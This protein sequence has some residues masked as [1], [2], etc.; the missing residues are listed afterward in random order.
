MRKQSNLPKTVSILFLML[1]SFFISLTATGQDI[2]R[3]EHPQPQF[4]RTKWINLNGTWDFTMQSNIE[5]ASE[6]WM[7]KPA[8]FDRKII[9][10]F[11]PESPLSGIGYTDYIHV[12]WYKRTFRIPDDWKGQRI[13]VNFG[14]VDFDSRVWVNDQFIGRHVGGTGSFEYEIT[15]AI[16]NGDNEIVIHS[17]DNVMDDRQPLGKQARQEKPRWGSI[18][19]T[20]VTGIWQTVWLEARPEKFIERVNIVPDLDKNEFS[21]T[22]EFNG[23]GQGDIFEIVVSSADGKKVASASAPATDGYPLTVKIL[24]PR[25]WTTTDPYLYNFDLVLKTA[26]GETDNVKSYAGMRKFH[27]EGNRFFLNNKPIFLRMVLDQG[28]YP[29]GQWT[30]PTDQALKNDIQLSIDAG[31]NSARLHQKVF[32]PR[33]HYWADKLGYLTW[34]EFSDWGGVH[35]FK[36]VEGLYI[37]SNEWREAIMRDR[38]HPSIIAWTPFNETSGA[39]SNDIEFY[40]YVVKNFYDLTHALDP[41]RPVNT[42]SGYVNVYT[43]IFTVHDYTQDH[44]TFR[45]RYLTVDPKNPEKAWVSNPKLSIPYAGQPY[46][47]DEYG[48][49]GWLPSYTDSKPPDGTTNLMGRFAIG[50]GKTADEVLVIV[51]NLTDALLDNPNVSGFTY[52]QLTDVEGEVNG[53]YYYDRK[54]KF[55][56]KKF[57][58]ILTKPAAIEQ[59]QTLKARP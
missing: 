32:E 1:I 21:V 9:V 59:L 5:N 45:E 53:V 19:Y 31:F 55:D 47:V 48:G 30:A 15:K 56:I 29:D 54:P 57:R 35:N 50:Y 25:L 33:F 41:S 44:V 23:A 16:K 3:P 36:S 37:Q 52:C 27:I 38:N 7:R 49:T 6:S 14:A 46:V 13:F 39:A 40:R 34:A 8:S 12:V 10:P 28:Y 18:T 11:A 43:D 26:S 4:V 42:T 22:P 17:Y 51:K 24:K 58:E 20:R 2:P